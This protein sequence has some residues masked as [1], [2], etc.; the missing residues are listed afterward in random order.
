LFYGQDAPVRI[1][2]AHRKVETNYYRNFHD[3][4]V[5]L[6]FS[7]SEITLDGLQATD[8]TKVTGLADNSSEPGGSPCFFGHLA[9]VIN[10]LF[11]TTDYVCYTT[12][13][14]SQQMTMTTGKAM[15]PRQQ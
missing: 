2:R 5:F 8:T 12:T 1:S 11:T 9:P 14:K 10:D 3:C 4:S 6:F 15:P 7:A 13:L